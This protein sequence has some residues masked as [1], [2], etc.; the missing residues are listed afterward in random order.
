MTPSAISRWHSS[1]AVVAA[2]M[3]WAAS[4]L[5]TGYVYGLYVWLTGDLLLRGPWQFL[6][7]PDW[8]DWILALRNATLLF[9]FAAAI[10]FVVSAV[11][12]AWPR[13]R[14]RQALG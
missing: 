6:A 1:Q 12:E 14:R 9:F 2:T 8:P 10:Y 7:K 5:S 4:L 11:A 3:A 13:W